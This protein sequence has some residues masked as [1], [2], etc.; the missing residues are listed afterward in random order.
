MDSVQHPS[1]VRLDVRGWKAD[2]SSD[3]FVLYHRTGQRISAFEQLLRQRYISALHR[4]A[5]ARAGDRLSFI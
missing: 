2:A 3:A 1:R 4:F 5:D